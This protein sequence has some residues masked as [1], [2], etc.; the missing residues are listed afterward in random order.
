MSK[1]EVVDIALIKIQETGF[2]FNTDFDYNGL[3]KSNIALKYGQKFHI[4]LNANTIGIEIT[5]IYTDKTTNADL[6]QLSVNSIYSVSELNLILRIEDGA[7]K[8]NDNRI[9]PELVNL[10]I[11]TIRGILYTKLKGTALDDLPLPLIPRNTIAQIGKIDG[12]KVD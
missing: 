12:T 3:Q 10:S 5:F 6:T 1:N 2:M 8:T 11:G 9:I 7:Y 4:D